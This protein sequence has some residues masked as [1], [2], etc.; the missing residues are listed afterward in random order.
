MPKSDKMTLAEEVR[1]YIEMHCDEDIT[2]DGL[3]KQFFVGKSHLLHSF[4]RDEGTSPMRYLNSYRIEKAK[5]LLLQSNLSIESIALR[6]AFRDRFHFSSE[7]KRRIGI[8][9]GEFRKN[10]IDIP[11]KAESKYL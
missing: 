1:T 2:L 3:C 8:P 7:F 9:P 11:Q 5:E 6:L 10:G 4:K